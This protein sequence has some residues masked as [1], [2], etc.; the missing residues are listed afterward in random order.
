MK[1]LKGQ[2]SSL[3]LE[4]K[5]TQERL[6]SLF[7]IK[8]CVNTIVTGLVEPVPKEAILG[9]ASARAFPVRIKICV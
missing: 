3:M 7:L 8:C 2:T 4:V 9:N 6:S 1:S 5:L